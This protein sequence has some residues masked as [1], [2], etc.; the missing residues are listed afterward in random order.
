MNIQNGLWFSVPLWQHLSD[1]TGA[2]ENTISFEYAYE[3][4]AGEV[5]SGTITLPVQ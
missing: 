3:T 5:E 2:N 4:K 1:D